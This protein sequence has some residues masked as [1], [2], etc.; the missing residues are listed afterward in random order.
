M[1]AATAGVV[2]AADGGKNSG[3]G[4]GEGDQLFHDP[5][6]KFGAGGDGEF[7]E[8]TVQ[9]GVYRVLRYA[10]SAGNARLVVI[11]KDALDNLQL[12]LRQV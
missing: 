5:Q 12:A 8:Q 6:H 3:F 9:M 10:E 7:L 11:V 4:K 1:Q 2:A